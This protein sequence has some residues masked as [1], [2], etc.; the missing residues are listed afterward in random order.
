MHAGSM[1]VFGGESDEQRKA[2]SS[3]DDE[4]HWARILWRL[5]I[6]SWQWHRLTP[7]VRR[8]WQFV[9]VCFPVAHFLPG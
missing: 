3:I 4:A 8:S 9:F 2:T 6:D 1:Y 7:E 5:D